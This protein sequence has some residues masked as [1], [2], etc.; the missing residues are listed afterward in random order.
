VRKRVINHFEREAWIMA[1]ILPAIVL[2]GIV[3]GLALPWLQRGLGLHP[4]H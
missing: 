2:I 3:V 1:L 4:G